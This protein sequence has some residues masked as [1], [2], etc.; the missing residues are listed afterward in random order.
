MMHKIKNKQKFIPTMYKEVDVQPPSISDFNK[1]DNK[2][3][4]P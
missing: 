3:Y 4:T 1:K 2:I